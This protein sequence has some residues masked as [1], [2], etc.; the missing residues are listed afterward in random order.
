MG[1]VRDWLAGRWV[2]AALAVGGILLVV[3]SL[4]APTWQMT[5]AD[6]EHGSLLS[7]QWEWSWGRVRVTGLEGVELRDQWN[8]L[9]LAL[10]VVLLLAALGGIG[11]WVLGGARDGSAGWAGSAGSAGAT[12]RA[13]GRGAGLVGVGLL[14]GQVLT[15]VTA[16]IGRSFGE[17]DQGVSGLTVRTDMTG[18]GSCETA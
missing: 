8:P 6:R 17:V 4:V 15:T 16:R 10:L 14:T 11:V 13:W 7:Q 2:G 9:G 18:A 1:A 12:V 3:P 5:V